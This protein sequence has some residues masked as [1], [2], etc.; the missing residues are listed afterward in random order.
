MA[1]DS[2]R[3]E[4]MKNK[5]MGSRFLRPYGIRDGGR[6]PIGPIRVVPVAG[7]TVSGTPSRSD[8][9]W[10]EMSLRAASGERK[11][12]TMHHDMSLR[13]APVASW[14]RPPLGPA[15]G[16]PHPTSCK[17]C[18]AHRAIGS[19]KNHWRRRPPMDLSRC[20][21]QRSFCCLRGLVGLSLS[22][23][24]GEAISLNA[25]KTLAVDLSIGKSWRANVLALAVTDATNHIFV[26]QLVVELPCLLT[27]H[28]A[29]RL[30]V[31]RLHRFPWNCQP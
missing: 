22:V 15:R 25:V 29:F 7:G 9:L 30:P 1:K 19:G 28:L 3:F 17:C 10:F 24:I 20:V 16:L 27:C 8:V 14:D 2:T 5:K 4:S 21:W 13:S 11:S 23:L 31:L 18:S 6:T 12:S 26:S